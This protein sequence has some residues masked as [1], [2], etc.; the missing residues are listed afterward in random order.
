MPVAS[1]QVIELVRVWVAS[2]PGSLG[3]Y[4]YTRLPFGVASVPAMFQRAMDIIL[5]GIPSV[6]GYIDDIL[7]SGDTEEQHL[8]RLEQV[9]KQLHEYGLRLIML[10]SSNEPKRI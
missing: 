5:Q 7:V 1:W 4:Q 2:S 3:L 8:D 10:R 9:L 6:V